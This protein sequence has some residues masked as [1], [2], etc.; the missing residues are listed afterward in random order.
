MQAYQTTNK[1]QRLQL[2]ES[3]HTT[4]TRKL[5]NGGDTSTGKERDAGISAALK[6]IGPGMMSASSKSV[7]NHNTENEEDTKK[8]KK[9]LV[10]EQ[11]DNEVDVIGTITGGTSERN[12]TKHKWRNSRCVSPQS[13]KVVDLNF[14]SP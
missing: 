3:M 4:L 13:S 2:Q 9:L 7:S 8:R 14:I 5:G 10:S 1:P 12:T 11:D 6:Q